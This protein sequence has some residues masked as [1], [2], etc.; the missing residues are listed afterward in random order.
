MLPPKESSPA[1]DAGDARLSPVASEPATPDLPG[2]A[3]EQRLRDRLERFER[4]ARAA[5]DA[6]WEWNIDAGEL[7]W[8]EG[9]QTL[10]GHPSEVTLSPQQWAAIVHPDDVDRVLTGLRNVIASGGLFWSDEYR[11]QRADGSYARVVGR[12]LVHRD[13]DGRA[14]GVVGAVQDVT[15]RRH[16]EEALRRSERYLSS[17]IAS[18]DGIVWEADAGTFDFTFV[19]SQAE[20]LLGYPTSQWIDEPGFW[21]AHLHPDDRDWALEQCRES[22]RARRGHQFE[23][24]MLAA[25]GHYVWLRDI[26]STVEHDGVLK[27]RGIMVDVTPQKAAEA[28]LL[29]QDAERSATEE[30]VTRQ[31]EALIALTGRPQLSESLESSLARIAETAA[32]TL[33]VGRVSIWRYSP[34]RSAIEC[35]VLYEL[36]SGQLLACAPLAAAN[37]PAYFRALDSSEVIAADDA[38]ADARTREFADGYL[39]PLGIR[40]MLDAAVV[41]DGVRAGVLCHEHLGA[42]RR[43]TADEKTFAV[44]LANLVAL[45]FES[46]QRRESDAERRRLEE[47]FL[48]AQ[49]MEAIGQLAGGVAHDF[50][51]ILSAILMQ[52]EEAELA[53]GLPEEAREGLEQIRGAADRAADLTRQLLVFGRRQVMQSRDVDLNKV[54]TSLVRMLKRIIPEPVELELRL[55][56]GRLTTHADPGMLDQVLLNLV[57]NARDAMPQGGRLIIETAHEDIDAATAR[58]IVDAVAGRY[59][60]LRVTDTGTGIPADVLP[61]IFE[62]FFTTKGPGHGTGLGLATVFAIVKQHRGWIEVDSAIGRGT[63][64]TIRLPALSEAAA[65]PSA[66][67]PTGAPRGGTETI[68][69]VEDDDQVRRLI[70]TALLRNGY[71]V[72]IADSGDQALQ[73][74]QAHDT[75]ISMLVTDLVMPGRV[76][77]MELSRRLRTEAPGLKVIFTSG[78]SPDT[79]GRE[80]ELRSGENFIQKPFA[81]DRLLDMI[82]RALDQ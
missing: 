37:H 66:E 17:L 6:L 4:L 60:V 19:S 77:G 51:N 1:R 65:V 32:R 41:L 82:R 36:A 75:S 43:W 61:R 73:V 58:R 26:V 11:L 29:A 72:L 9:F 46:A 63:S 15:E 45:A 12:G 59:A 21:A 10:F 16:S 55:G 13:E 14:R 39:R 27:L 62:P 64:F 40:A 22:V 48:Q 33:A 8:G 42:P 3:V 18:V 2:P 7:W 50:N 74:W 24:R 31:R 54:V 35:L 30:R 56:A 68:L 34:D 52:A 70:R 57:V 49:K 80:I 53:E 25:D 20:R 71:R 81:T 76:T 67:P 69:L 38:L 23:Y 44:A 47:Q 78:Y 28:A 79:A 5:N